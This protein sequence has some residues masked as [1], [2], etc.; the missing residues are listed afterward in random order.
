MAGILGMVYAAG[1][2]AAKE[3]WDII[4]FGSFVC[5]NCREGKHE[6]CAG[7]N[8]LDI[9]LCDR[10]KH[11]AREVWSQGLKIGMDKI[12]SMRIR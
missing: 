12:R 3:E 1:K 7:H 9:C 11:D 8:H 6:H 5:D 2:H 10:L 4:H